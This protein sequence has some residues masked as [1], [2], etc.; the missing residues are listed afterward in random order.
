MVCVSGPVCV[1]LCECEFLLVSVGLCAC[2]WGRMV[3]TGAWVWGSGAYMGI[4]MCV[5]VCVD[6][7]MCVCVCMCVYVYM[8][9]FGMNACQPCVFVEG[10]SV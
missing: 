4:Y 8:C 7:C 2:T 10:L 1:Y 6:V 9:G 3:C 5:Y